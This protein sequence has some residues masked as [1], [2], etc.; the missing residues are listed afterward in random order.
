[1]NKH[2]SLQSSALFSLSAGS[3][4]LYRSLRKLRKVFP[5]AFTFA[6]LAAFLFSLWVGLESSARRLNQLVE[7]HKTTQFGRLD[8]Q[9]HMAA[10]WWPY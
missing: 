1:M 7:H 3:S 5:Y 8:A 2:G 6:L 4:G 10:V 9:L